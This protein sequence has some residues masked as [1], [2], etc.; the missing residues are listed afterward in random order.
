M[1]ALLILLVLSVGILIALGLIWLLTSFIIC[2]AIYNAGISGMSPFF[3]AELPILVINIATGSI[4]LV[5]VLLLNIS[6][7]VSD[8]TQEI[9]RSSAAISRSLDSISRS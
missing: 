9:A 6:M 8:L 4:I 1:A 3:G 2:S 7:G 5:A